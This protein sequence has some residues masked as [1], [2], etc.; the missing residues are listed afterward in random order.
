MGICGINLCEY[1]NINKLVCP[2]V[3]HFLYAYHAHLSYNNYRLYRSHLL[4]Q[5]TIFACLKTHV[6]NWPGL[7]VS[8]W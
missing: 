8:L 2:F 4:P 5:L 1:L 3:C 7:L 6:D